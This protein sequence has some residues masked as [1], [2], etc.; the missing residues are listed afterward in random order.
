MYIAEDIGE[1]AFLS[2]YADRHEISSFDG[3]FLGVVKHHAEILIQEE[4]GHISKKI[5]KM[6]EKFMIRMFF[7][8]G[9]YVL[10]S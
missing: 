7:V 3:T 10:C 8:K 4:K 2:R 5:F 1:S 9:S 6:I